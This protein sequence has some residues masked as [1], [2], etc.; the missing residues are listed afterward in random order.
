LRKNGNQFAID[1]RQEAL[2][3][4][5]FQRKSQTETTTK[6]DNQSQTENDTVGVLVAMLQRELDAKTRQLEEK[7]RQLTAKDHQIDEL[8]AT[9]KTQAQSIN[10]AHQTELAGKL[11]EG[12]QLIGV[13]AD[14]AEP[15]QPQKKK[16]LFWKR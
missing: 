9:V 6:N 12:K 2:I 15:E 7:D 14:P 8:T 16:W 11:I 3:L 10:A 4:Q 1:E 5:A 13:G